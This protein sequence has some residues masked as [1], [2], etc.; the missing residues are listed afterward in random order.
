[1]GVAELEGRAAATPDTWSVHPR[2]VCQGARSSLTADEIRNCC[3]RFPTSSTAEFVGRPRFSR[4]TCSKRRPGGASLAGG[5]LS[6]L[7]P[8]ARSRLDAAARHCQPA[9]HGRRT[10]FAE[11]RE[12]PHA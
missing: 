2:L 6:R 4:L 5:R 3:G 8:A 10:E 12:P 1:M 9:V 11:E 7:A